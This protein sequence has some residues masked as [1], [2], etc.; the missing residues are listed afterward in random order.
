MFKD[1]FRLLRVRQWLKNILLF[2]PIFFSGHFIEI[3]KLEKVFISF[4]SFSLLAS[5]CYII[6]DIKDI[7]SDKLHPKKCQRPIASGKISKTNAFI[8]FIFLLGLSFSIST[9]INPK[10]SLINMLYF[11]NVMLYTYIFKKI[12][13]LDIIFISVGFILRLYA[14]SVPIDINLSIWLIIITFLVAI[15]LGFGKR[16]EDIS[17]CPEA[18]YFIFNYSKN[19][20]K[21]FLILSGF[22]SVATFSLY[23]YFHNYFSIPLLV[24]TA[25][26]IINYIF[27]AL[28]K[29]QGEPT[30]FF[31]SNIFNIF[32]LIL[33]ATIFYF[34]IYK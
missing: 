14:G 30:D 11:T 10:L 6:N 13:Y 1:I 20:A 22:L 4:I 5:A 21:L 7:Q 32:M 27:S 9:A 18:R 12:P 34:R 3:E 2:F 33:W 16:Y 26:L 24:I 29:F 17:K 19:W 8:I 15:M 23:L 28:I 31:T 25:V